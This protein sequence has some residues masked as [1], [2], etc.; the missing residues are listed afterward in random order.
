[1]SAVRRTGWRGGAVAALVV[2]LVLVSLTPLGGRVGVGAHRPELSR[3]AAGEPGAALQLAQRIRRGP[4]E[5]EKPAEA[6]PEKPAA[7]ELPE[8]PLRRQS[9]ADADK[10]S[11]GCMTC[12]T[13]TDS[14]SMHTSTAVKLGCLDCHGG[15]ND[16]KAPADATAGS[17]AYEAA[18][19]QAHV[20]PREANVWKTSANPQLSYTALLR[21]SLD[22]AQ[23]VNPGDLRVARKTCGAG[24]CHP[25][26]V[27]QVEKSMMKTGPMLWGAALYNNGQIPFKHAR[28]GESYGTDG[29]P[30]RL[31]TNPPPKPEEIKTKGVMAFMDPLLRF[32]IGQP[33]NI[34]RIFERGQEKP[35]EIGTPNL[36]E[37]PGRPLNRLSQRGLG[38]LNRIDPV[39]LN[40]QRTRLFDPS[41]SLLGPNTVPGDFRSSGCSGCHV[42]YANDRDKTHAAEYAEFGNL[43]RTQTA[44]PTIP[45][46][47]SG[48]PVRHTFT[49]SIPTSQCVV[50]HHHPGTTV[51]NSYLGNIWWDN[52]SDGHHMY[53]EKERKLT[54]TEV[55]HIQ[56][57]NPE[58]AALRG[59]W[60]D[61]T[62]LANL[63]DLNPKLARVQFADHHGHGWVFRNVYK[64]DR[65][66]HM[67]DADNKIV[68]AADPDRFQK[69]VHLKDIHLEKG[70]HCS[71]CHFSQDNHGNGKLYGETRA[72]VEITCVDCHGTINAR[73][74][75]KTSGPAAPP[76]GTDLSLLG[77]PAG[78]RRFQWRGDTLIQRSTVTKGLEW[79]VVQVIDSIDPNSE[80][81][82]KNP[83]RAE[84]S[85]LAKT[86]RKDGVTWGDAAD[87][88]QLAHADSRMTCFTCHTSWVTS[89]FGCHLPMKANERKP[90][91]HNEGAVQRNWTPYNFQTVRDDVFMLAQD[92]TVMGK[93]ISPAR[94]TCAVMVGS[95]NGTREWVYSQ[96]QTVSA[97]GFAGH[98]FSTF[99]PHTVRAT[100]TKHCNDCHVTKAN[101]N[102]AW[103]ASVLMQGTNFYNF[104]GRYAYVA[105]GDK[106]LRA[107]V[108]TERAEPQAVIGST[109]HKIA[110]PE[111]YEKHQAR[112]GELDEVEHH[113][114]RDVLDIF[115]RDEVQ[116]I[117]VRGEY[118]YTANGRGGYRFYDVAQI[119]QK[120]FSER[121]VTAPV[122]PLGQRFYVKSKYATAIASPTTLGV[123]PTRKHLPENEE[124]SIH[125]VYAFLYGTDR[126]EGFIVIGN[127][128]D[129]PNRAGVATLLDGDPTNNFIERA[130]TFNPDGLL[131]GAV[132]LT[133]A[134]HYAYV[135]APKGLFVISLENPLKPQ[136]VANI[137]APAIVNPRAVAV[138]FRYAFVT[139]SEGLKVVEVTD[140]TKP[141][142]VSGAVVKLPDAH[143]IY[144]ARTYAYVAAGA[145]GLAIV[146][147]E[148][149]EAPALDQMYDAGGALN[150]T[151]DV[152]VAM[153]NASLF[154]YVADGKNGFRVLQ[155]T[156]PEDTPTY[157]GFSPRPQPRL[158]ATAHTGGPALAVSKGIDRDRAVDES[159]HQVAVFNR[160]GSRPFT[161]AEQQ[162][163]YLRDGKLYTVSEEP[164]SAPRAPAAP[165][166]EEP[167]ATEPEGGPRLRRPR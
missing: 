18:K 55:D 14:Q 148:R 94:S 130:V 82:K 46:N 36:E 90:M 69:A 77:T 150:D 70:M 166:R 155:L 37:P 120:G 157:L 63:R 128:L 163:L 87:D 5:E 140:P 161:L 123:D 162:R 154:A 103:M 109:L 54:A 50:C 96:Q 121:I 74:N 115:G 31:L 85:R 61:P 151:R 25:D 72:A 83:K 146:D 79:E 27:T 60:S 13:K 111:E 78:P 136:I 66:G 56:R 99:V 119:D 89:C 93:K 75:L 91:L 137:G 34:L 152:K 15:N 165:K 101:D 116:S 156:S 2:A 73:A 138:Q 144:V 1:M 8:S 139:D 133:I 47:E 125:L 30:N 58:G 11:A 48:H 38:T 22:F 81:A 29:L 12:H 88:K 53:P 35:L 110:F 104:I 145:K 42:I 40:L 164:P 71:D 57:L 92:G 33:G 147:V 62:F 134:G 126:E 132:N 80:W 64:T 43:G 9:Q 124:Q 76:G 160:V 20:A 95:Q 21:E 106:G 59:K 16:V 107:V 19:K 117:Q 41:L 142:A 49:N 3:A 7:P 153:T 23:F 113:R 17:P 97:E 65:K 129:S 84:R 108:V 68:D 6:A 32:E 135:L 167:A 67:L 39:W 105:A 114:G 141:R 118:L 143:G 159:G 51:T 86:L 158:I 24:G 122:S 52:E 45:R 149:P 28:Y 4:A 44:D 112:K 98:A 102:N 131:T 100:E 26:Q 127:P 10:K